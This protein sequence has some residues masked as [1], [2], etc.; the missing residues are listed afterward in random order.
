MILSLVFFTRRYGEVNE[1]SVGTICDASGMNR[2]GK[3]TKI[4]TIISFSAFSESGK[5]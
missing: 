1:K 3:F 5:I 4:A 2:I